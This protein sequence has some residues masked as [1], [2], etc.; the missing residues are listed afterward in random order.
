MSDSANP[1]YGTLNWPM[2]QEWFA[3]APEDDGQFW[4][5]NL[6]KYRDIADYSDGRETTLTGEE[7]DDIYAPIDILESLGAVPAFGSKVV[8][9]PAGEPAWDRIAIVRY[10]S[11]AKFFEMQRM[12]IFVER[13]EHKDAGMEFTIVMSCDPRDLP[14][15]HPTA[16]HGSLVMTVRRFADRSAAA[17]ETEGVASVAKFD[18]EGQ[19]VGDEREWHEVRFDRVAGGSLDRFVAADN[20]EEQIVVV[21]DEAQIIDV[22]TLVESIASRS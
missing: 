13:H 22:G 8:A 15:E 16:E 20:V 4:A 11:R 7:A 18:V 21:L 17:A 14:E 19:M 10:P 1:R 2:L 12:P 3:R 6:M 5:I 9:Q